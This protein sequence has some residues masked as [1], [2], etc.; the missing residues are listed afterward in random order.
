MVLKERETR[1]NNFKEFKKQQADTNAEKKEK[2]DEKPIVNKKE[3]NNTPQKIEKKEQKRLENKERVETKKRLREEEENSKTDNEN[4]GDMDIESNVSRVGSEV[5]KTKK[6][7]KSDGQVSSDK[8]N[9]DVEGSKKQKVTKKRDRIEENENENDDITIDESSTKKSKDERE[10]EKAAKRKKID[11]KRKEVED[12]RLEK[13]LAN[14]EKQKNGGRGP[15]V[16]SDNKDAPVEKKEK[17]ANRFQKNKIKNSE[18]G[19]VD[20]GVKK[21]KKAKNTPEENGDDEKSEKKKGK[22]KGKGK[23]KGKKGDAAKDVPVVPQWG[24]FKRMRAMKKGK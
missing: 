11:L 15:K 6:V 10:S 20:S 18:V 16:V 23:G 4:E 7:K 2:S 22:D 21:I 1:S 9:E 3:L 14:I 8:M 19:G 12:I 13:K 17:L 5:K 24:G